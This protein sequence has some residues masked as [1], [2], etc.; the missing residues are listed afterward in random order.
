LNN[1]NNHNYDHFL[2]P[3]ERVFYARQSIDGTQKVIDECW[4]VIT[5]PKETEERKMMALQLA[6]EGTKNEIDMLKT[7]KQLFEGLYPITDNDNDYG[8]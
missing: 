1:K 5:N 7:V 3:N 6:F 8:R 4:K 2:T